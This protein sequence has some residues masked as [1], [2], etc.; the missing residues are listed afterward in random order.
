MLYL[1]RRGPI[2]SL[3]TSLWRHKTAMTYIALSHNRP[4]TLKKPVAHC[5]GSTSIC[6]MILFSG[7]LLR[8]R[9]VAWVHTEIATFYY[10]CDVPGINVSFV[11]TVDMM[12]FLRGL[13]PL[14]LRA[15]GHVFFIHA[16]LCNKHTIRRLHHFCVYRSIH[17]VQGW[18]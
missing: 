18:C 14:D 11:I 8:E 13:K 10:Q 16:P 2:I 1:F 12:C 9:L 7:C 17:H 5:C 15:L 6:F 4:T 3:S